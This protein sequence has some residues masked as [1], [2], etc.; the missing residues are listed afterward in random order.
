MIPHDLSPPLSF[1][2]SLQL[3]ARPQPHQGCALSLAL[4]RAVFMSLSAFSLGVNGDF[5]FPV[6]SLIIH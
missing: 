5:T 1:H 3:P 4:E 6:F 2:H